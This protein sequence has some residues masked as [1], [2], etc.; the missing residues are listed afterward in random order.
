MKKI[1]L[2]L[3]VVGTLLGAQKITQIKYV[4]LAHLSP[5]VATEVSGIQ[6]GDE[7]DI[8]KINQSIKNFY[9]QGYFKDVWV[10]SKGS[11]LIY[12]FDE[13][14]AIANIEIKGFGTGDEGKKLL[15]S[16]GLKKGD[17]YD[18]RRV[19][20]AKKMLISNL[21]SQGFYDTVV[22]ISMEKVTESS[23][24]LI[25]D[26]NKGEKIT[27]E[28]MNLVGAK[29]VEKDDLESNLANK[30]AD[31]L[32]WIPIFNDGV[33]KVDQLEYDSYRLKDA[34]MQKGYLD[35]EVS[36]PLM[37][38][39]FGSY[40]ADIDYQIDE[41]VQ[42]RIGKILI[43]QKLKGL[44]S[45]E[46]IDD[47]TLKA[48][49]VFNI[50]RMRSDMNSLKEKIGNLGYA[51]VDIAPQMHKDEKA[52]TIDLNYVIKE[53][54]PV[55]INDVLISG[56]NVTKDR[57]IRR[58]IYLAPGDKFNATDLKDSKNALGRTGF[59]EKV[60]IETQRISEDR[61]N[62]LVKVKEAPTGTISAGGGYG[63]YEGL[64]VNASISD[65]NIFG[66][67]INTSLGFDISKIS[68]NYNVS[69]T[70]PRVWDSLYSMG[71]SIYK[72]NYEYI[73]F[74]QDQ[75]GVNLSFGRQFYRH[76]YASIGFGYVDNQSETSD[77]SD[78][79]NAGTGSIY[80]SQFYDVKY[81]KTSG[82]GSLK[83]DNTDDYYQ[84]REGF[85]AVGSVEYASLDGDLDQ[86]S[87]AEGYTDFANF[88]KLSGKFGAYYGMEDILDYDLILRAKARFTYLLAGENEYIPIAERLA[89][90]GVGSVRGYEPYSL[91]PQVVCTAYDMNNQC[92][93]YRAAQDGESGEDVRGTKRASVS[94]EAS[95]P[96]S[97]AAK[98]R[99]A[100]FVDYGL[101]G[102]DSI[103]SSSGDLE[104]SDITRSSTGAVIEWQSG[105]GPINLVFAHAINPKDN[106]RTSVFEFSMGT[107]F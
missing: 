88:V 79:P 30:E 38:V 16:T 19:K 53:G 37:K 74:T 20:K 103:P 90:G 2:S 14:L 42:Y 71:L 80:Y 94:L 4:G 12:H 73:D 26:V 96:L 17:L 52:R 76:L 47:L 55:T 77:N 93:S 40:R 82:F 92:I 6:V 75:L 72:K 23:V 64:M 35:A 95:I 32:G 44:D 39:D 11:T 67:G 5:S 25:F 21:E 57:V 70:N 106:D 86:E 27:I 54:K 29:A 87:I 18:K 69:F 105:F 63:S 8:V 9:S 60:D 45:K 24:S 91:T 41:G 15:A 78:N 58:Y 34:Y 31:W 46:L 36:K 10:E 85:I 98:M 99:L 61:I 101:I 83:F 65:K 56:N 81:K 48:G 102:T 33:A 100:F 107:K 89:M 59:F 97:E 1:A 51:Y 43:T 104:F 66:S 3:F 7:M 49:K 50:N 62:L 13:K 28:K 84:P 22:E 68:T